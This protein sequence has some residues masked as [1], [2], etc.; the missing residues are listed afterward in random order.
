MAAAGFLAALKGLAGQGLK[1]L[2]T[3]DWAKVQKMFGSRLSAQLFSGRAKEIAMKQALAL[4]E[5]RMVKAVRS[6]GM[7]V[8]RPWPENAAST[9]DRKG[10]STPLIDKGD[11]IGRASCRERV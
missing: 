9:I 11:Q 8:G 2:G 6:R 7:T 3:A 1:L 5:R 10:S 4:L